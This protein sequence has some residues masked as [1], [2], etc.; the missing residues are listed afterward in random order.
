MAQPEKA[1][2]AKLFFHKTVIY[3]AESHGMVVSVKL[4]E[5]SHLEQGD[6]E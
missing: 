6:K 1:V 3:G 5:K 2:H 4:V